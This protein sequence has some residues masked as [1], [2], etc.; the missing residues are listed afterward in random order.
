MLERALAVLATV[1]QKLKVAKSRVADEHLD[2][3]WSDVAG[4]EIMISS[5]LGKTDSHEAR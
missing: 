1:D 2:A 5:H 4:L 3:T